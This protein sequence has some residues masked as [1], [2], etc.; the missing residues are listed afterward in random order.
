MFDGYLS[1]GGVEVMNQARTYAYVENSEC[2]AGWIRCM[3]CPGLENALGVDTYVGT[4]SQAPWYDEQDP[5]THRF[6]GFYPISVEGAEGSTRTAT[7]TEG[8][9]DG[10]VIGGTRKAVRTMRVRGVMVGLGHDGLD[11]GLSWLDKVLDGDQ[12]STHGGSCGEVDA[13]FFITCPPERPM[14]TDFTPFETVATNQVLNPSFETA[15]GTVEVRRNSAT[16]PI[17]TTAAWLT[18]NVG[19]YSTTLD[20]TGGRRGGAA[21]RVDRTASTPSGVLASLYN[22]GTTGWN[23]A[24]R[25]P[26]TA[27]QTWTNSFYVRTGT[28]LSAYSNI[29]TY[30][31]DAANAAVGSA[32]VSAPVQVGGG[33]WT[34]VSQTVTVPAGATNMGLGSNVALN[35][36][37]TAGGEQVWVADALIE[38]SSALMPYF[39]GGARPRLRENLI[40]NPI[41]TLIGADGTTVP[42]WTALVRQ[43]DSAVNYSTAAFYSDNIPAVLNDQ[44]GSS[45]VLMSPGGGTVMMSVRE[46]T[47]GLFGSQ[48]F[49][50]SKAVT[51]LPGVPQTVTLGGTITGPASDGIR[52]ASGAIPA[53]MV[54]A[55]SSAI[56]ERG[57]AAA[58]TYFDGSGPTVPGYGQNWNGGVGTS[59]S[60]RWDTDVSVSWTG[61]ANAS[62]SIL[63]GVGI[64]NATG[65]V[66]TAVSYTQSTHWV[67]TG[68][69]SLRLWRKGTGD[70]YIVM[71]APGTAAP[72]TQWTALITTRVPEPVTLGGS[73]VMQEAGGAFRNVATLIPIGTVLTGVQT[74]RATFTNFADMSATGLRIVMRST[75]AVNE[76]IWYD[77]FAVVAGNYLGDYFDGNTTPTSATINYRWLGTTDNSQSIQEVR[78]EIQVPASDDVYDDMLTPLQRRIHGVTAVSGPLV[79]NHF[80]NQNYHAYEVEFTLAAATP[81][82]YGVPVILPPVS[83]TSTII[84]D[85][86]FNLVPYP[87]AELASTTEVTTATN[88]STNPS[89]ETN[90]TGWASSYDGTAITTGSAA[91]V[92]STPGTDPAAAGTRSVKNVWTAPNSGSNGWFSTQQEVTVPTTAGRRFSVN[93]WATANVTSGTAVIGSIQ[94]TLYWRLGGSTARTD[95]LGAFPVGG[96][97]FSQKSI[98]PPSGATSVIVR[99]RCVLS[100]WSTGAVVTLFTDALAVT[101][102]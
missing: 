98:I 58:G 35:S 78:S 73:V 10:G 49:V 65:P 96:G 14:V 66:T 86:P 97:A 40:T 67:D 33:A 20:A 51:L 84:Q 89:A 23:V 31:F 43:G 46:T 5:A 9:T 68:T 53:G 83:Q 91:L 34:R 52:I 37:V 62:A 92:Q 77:S 48:P 102:P 70:A 61:T 36:G 56:V 72:S 93:M 22:I 50:Q 60:W 32:I 63:S 57:V 4:L 18:N 11:A 7:I 82:V 81:Y 28:A 16:V 8:I 88:Y 39:D 71:S 90:V 6:L 3:P 38:Q 17:P 21:L 54:I 79:L 19:L 99:A 59:T 2:P 12:C 80:H 27:G 85:A 25:V 55:I 74:W 26:V 41:P 15:S 95:E 100:S 76:S 42:G 94:L 24:G 30:F 44:V 64:L 69:K 87:S 1:L 47:G 101:I 75:G 29:V 45:I 13:C